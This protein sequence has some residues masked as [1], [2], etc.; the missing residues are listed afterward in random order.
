MTDAQLTALLG[1]VTLLGAGAFKFI[2]WAVKEWR[3]ERAAERTAHERRFE[4][5]R[6]DRKQQRADE[7]EDR[8]DDR[9]ALKENTRAVADLAGLMR[10]TSGRVTT[11]ADHVSGVHDVPPDLEGPPQ[12]RPALPRLPR[13]QSEPGA[14]RGG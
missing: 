7:R 4:A 5:D 11:I 13:L 1:V 2:A 6:E 10:E 14:R 9:D 8:K 12:P 3:D